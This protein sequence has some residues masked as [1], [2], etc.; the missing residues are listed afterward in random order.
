MKQSISIIE[1]LLC[2][3]NLLTSVTDSLLVYNRPQLPY[4]NELLGIGLTNEGFQS[5]GQTISS[6]NCVKGLYLYDIPI[7]VLTTANKEL[8][9]IIVIHKPVRTGSRQIDNIEVAKIVCDKDILA[10]V[11]SGQNHTNFQVAIVKILLHV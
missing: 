6:G 7:T 11:S 3:G 2:C 4:G 10:T 5:L 8:A 1:L 9:S